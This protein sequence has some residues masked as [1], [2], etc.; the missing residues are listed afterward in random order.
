[1]E[2]SYRKIDRKLDMT[3]SIL[4]PSNKTMKLVESLFTKLKAT[5]L[6]TFLNKKPLIAGNIKW[7]QLTQKVDRVCPIVYTF[8]IKNFII[9]AFHS[10]QMKFNK[11]DTLKDPEIRI[12]KVD[13]SNM[14]VQFF[15]VKQDCVVYRNKS[16]FFGNPSS[17]T[18]NFSDKVSIKTELFPLKK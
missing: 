17:F 2:V 7:E 14:E 5:D 13:R 3:Y 18:I 10:E 8:I 11:Y 9:G 12:F 16:V 6:L 1:M 4:T 15:G